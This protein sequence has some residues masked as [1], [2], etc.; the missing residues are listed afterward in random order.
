MHGLDIACGHPPEARKDPE[1]EYARM[2]TSRT[3]TKILEEL[4]TVRKWTLRPF[5]KS[6]KCD[7]GTPQIP[8]VFQFYSTSFFPS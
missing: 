4:R 3:K 7:V 6:Q 5:L 1:T 8:L 2:K